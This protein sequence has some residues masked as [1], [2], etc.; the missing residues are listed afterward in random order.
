MAVANAN[1]KVNKAVYNL[2]GKTVSHARTDV[3]VRDV[4]VVTDEPLERGGTNVAASPTE[5]M[6]AA[7]VGCTNNVATRIAHHKGLEFEIETIE[8]EV[9]FDRRGVILEEDIAVPF[10]SIK[11]TINVRATA[12]PEQLAEVEGLLPIYCPVSKVFQAAGTDV[13]ETWN[14][15]D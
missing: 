13:T 6:I 4:T 3:S 1:V 7:L 11:L 9:E 8:A 12:T 14:V 10:P 2:V 5:T 15:I